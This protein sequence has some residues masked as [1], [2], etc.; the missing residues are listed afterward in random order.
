[1]KSNTCPDCKIRPFIESWCDVCKTARSRQNSIKNNICF[2]CQKHTNMHK[3]KRTNNLRNIF[4]T[5]GLGDDILN[6][7]TAFM[8]HENGHILQYT[9]SSAIC[10]T[11][12]TH[13][14]VVS[15]EYNN[16]DRSFTWLEK[17]KICS[18]CLVHGMLKCMKH[19]QRYPVK[20]K[21]LK[22]FLKY[23]KNKI[24]IRNLENN[25]IP[26]IYKLKR[27]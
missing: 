8:T 21:D 23:S 1:M 5:L 7:I 26:P 14:T 15:V 19:T 4:L 27:Q 10:P 25:Y 20:S 24:E 2:V 17:F 12:I 18:H 3:I 22:Y 16:D 13:I 9:C 11:H 6:I